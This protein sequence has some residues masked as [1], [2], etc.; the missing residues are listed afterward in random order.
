MKNKRGEKMGFITLDD[1]SGRI[2]ASLFAEAFTNSHTLLQTDTLVVLEGE[3]S[4]DDFS[5]ALRVRTKRVLS[6]GEARTALAESLQ[7]RVTQTQLQGEILN[8]LA[9][10]CQKYS[11][12]CPI[13]LDYTGQEAQ[14]TLQLGQDWNIEPQD[15]LLQALRDQF[16][17]SNVSL[18]YR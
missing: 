17:P 9:Q 6:L 11:G 16:G 14:A 3:V 8:W 4:H 5:G 2:E 1:R 13:T 12:S 10:I 7:I 18:Q 15:A